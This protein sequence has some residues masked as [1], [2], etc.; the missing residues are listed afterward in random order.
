[1]IQ[2]TTILLSMLL[3]I[4]G[5]DRKNNEL[6]LW[7][8]KTSSTTAK[9][10][11][12]YLFWMCA[13]SNGKNNERGEYAKTIKQWKWQLTKPQFYSLPI[14]GVYFVC[15]V[16]FSWHIGP[17]V[18]PVFRLCFRSLFFFCLFLFDLSIWCD[19]MF[20]EDRFGALF[21]LTGH[22]DLL[23]FFLAILNVCIY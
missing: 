8:S 5:A 20:W 2:L 11:H 19:F 15:L 3:L 21:A 7:W 14:A 1:M 6:Y 23:S 12:R 22:V 16:F 9:N 4:D 18:C 13:I 17:F 10:I